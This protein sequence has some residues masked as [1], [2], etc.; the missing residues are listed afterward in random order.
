MGKD[1][2]CTLIFVRVIDIA[3]D[4]VFGVA[5]ITLIFVN[6]SKIAMGPTILVNIFTVWLL[7]KKIL[8]HQVF[9]EGEPINNIYTMVSVICVESSALMII[10]TSLFLL[11]TTK[12]SIIPN[13]P[14][15]PDTGLIP[16]QLMV[17][18]YVSLPVTFPFKQMKLIK[19][20]RF[21]HHFSSFT[22]W[23]GARP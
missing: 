2:Y 8:S 11:L 6:D 10:M 4:P 9:F 14:I 21:C 3:V 18:I 22:K 16:M 12:G 1:N 15:N 7:T 5:A 19:I 17:H 20:L 23:S 13:E